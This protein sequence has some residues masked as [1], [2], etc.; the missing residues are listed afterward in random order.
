MVFSNL[1]TQYTLHITT[2]SEVIFLVLVYLY[3]IF[4]YIGLRLHTNVRGYIV[5]PNL[6]VGLV[7]A[8]YTWVQH[9]CSQRLNFGSKNLSLERVSWKQIEYVF[10]YIY[11]RYCLV[12]LIFFLLQMKAFIFKICSILT[13]FPTFIGSIG[14]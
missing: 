9:H 6:K 2:H 14:Y 8:S 11:S 10:P 12:Q 4:L 3:N 1:V 7:A 5:Y 13:K